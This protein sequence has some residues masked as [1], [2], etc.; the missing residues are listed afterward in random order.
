[1][2]LNSNGKEEF[3]DVKIT[4]TTLRRVSGEDL[5]KELPLVFDFLTAFAIMPPDKSI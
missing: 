1:M 2:A 5:Q 3:Q 4:K